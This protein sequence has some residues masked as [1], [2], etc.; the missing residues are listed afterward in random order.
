[1]SDQLDQLCIKTLPFLSVDSVQQANSGVKY[2]VYIQ[3]HPTEN[4]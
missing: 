1:M 2:S 4:S 3:K